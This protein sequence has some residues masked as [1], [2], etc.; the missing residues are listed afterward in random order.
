V[1]QGGEDAKKEL[2]TRMTAKDPPDAF[3]QT[4]PLATWLTSGDG[5]QALDAIYTQKN[6]DST[7]SS[8]L[9]PGIT[10]DSK[11]YV[12]PTNVHS[13][14]YLF[15]NKAALAAAGITTPPS[16]FADLRAA[17]DT[18]KTATPTVTPLA[19]SYQGWIL[20]IIF[21]AVAVATGTDGGA[22]LKS[23]YAGTVDTAWL[24]QS[25]TNFDDLMTTCVNDDANQPD[26]VGWDKPLGQRLAAGTIAMFIHGD[27]LKGY[28]DGQGKTPGTDYDVVLF[29][30]GATGTTFLFNADGFALPTNAVNTPG[31][32]DFLDT[33]LKPD[34]QEAFGKLKGACPANRTVTTLASYDSV[35]K[36]ICTGM[37]GATNALLVQEAIDKTLEDGYKANPKTAVADLVT[38]IAALYPAP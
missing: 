23:L 22:K 30:G 10:I 37:A 4:G 6:W 16:T 11:K 19:A 2:A 21:D 15:Y 34:V 20:R 7:I 38:Q 14:N 5:I 18:I 25:L 3:Q 24:T 26:T 31:A 12:V 36:S 27:W 28:L 17:C 9:L 8:F 1:T 32:V 13:Q 29:P 33:F 35:A